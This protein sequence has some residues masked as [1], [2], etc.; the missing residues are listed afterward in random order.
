MCL[1][2]YYAMGVTPDLNRLAR[3]AIHNPDGH[4]FAIIHGENGKF[5]RGQMHLIVSK[6]MKSD[7]LI[8]EFGQMRAKYPEGP[9]LFHSRIATGGTVDLAN[10]HPFYAGRK[11]Q[12]K[13]DEQTVI[14]HNGI[15]FTPAAKENRSDTKI[16]ADD[17]FPANYRRMDKP[18]VRVNLERYLGTDKMVVLTANPAYDMCGYIF[19][20][21]L[22]TW[23]DGE[24]HS[25]N[26]H[27]TYYGS[28]TTSSRFGK[29][30]DEWDDVRPK[31]IRRWWE[32]AKSGESGHSA[33]TSTNRNILLNRG[34][35]CVVCLVRGEIDADTN[36]CQVCKTCQDC[37]AG[38]V[39]CL[40]YSP[41][42]SRRPSQWDRDDESD[43]PDVSEEVT[44][45]LAELDEDM[46]RSRN[47]DNTDDMVNTE[48][49]GRFVHLDGKLTRIPD[50]TDIRTPSAG[51]LEMSSESDKTVRK[52]IWNGSK[53]VLTHADGEKISH[54]PAPFQHNPAPR[55]I[56][57]G[58]DG[59]KVIPLTPD[60]LRAAVKGEDP[61][62]KDKPGLLGKIRN[63]TMIGGNS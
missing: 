58:K 34:T 9:A 25:N 3:A 24:W 60:E 17:L 42:T 22:G 51:V 57:S 15:L 61:G 43:D 45:M 27:T 28:Y 44:R 1:L 50:D 59:N 62:K 8:E 49:G 20:E 14:G 23:H 21:R 4:G 18:G 56:E 7:D 19:N 41:D 5:I 10:C 6:S 55:V 12:G 26:S 16:F 40:C 46:E 39:V 32:D 11:E 38:Q 47:A 29:Y 31:G 30:E 37:L 54:N 35:A 13:Y 53:Y 2:S 48:T 36:I 52:Y 63:L 33:N